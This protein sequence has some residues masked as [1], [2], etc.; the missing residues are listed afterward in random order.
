MT[1][2]EV[3]QFFLHEYNYYSK[4]KWIE[5]PI[6]LALHKTL[7]KVDKTYLTRLNKEQGE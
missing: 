6:T 4:C 5:N 7:L 2:I 3:L 1:L